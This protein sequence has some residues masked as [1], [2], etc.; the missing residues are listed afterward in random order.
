MGQYQMMLPC[1]T[2]KSIDSVTVV[3]RAR[4]N[5]QT[6]EMAP[7]YCFDEQYASQRLTDSSVT[8]KVLSGLV[9]AWYCV[10]HKI[11]GRTRAHTLIHVLVWE[12][13]GQGLAILLLE[14][15]EKPTHPQSTSPTFILS[16]SFRATSK[17]ISIQF[18]LKLN[19][20]KRKKKK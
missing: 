14:K 6:A 20:K 2:M 17:I 7:Y 8:T 1:P 3:V 4:N 15:C 11:H 9:S 18:L 19:R 16:S 13:K 10:L 5:E 12:C